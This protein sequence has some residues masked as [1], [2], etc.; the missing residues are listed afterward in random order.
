MTSN[1][2]LFNSPINQ[3]RAR[4]RIKKRLRKDLGAKVASAMALAQ[5]AVLNPELLTEEERQF[6]E[7]VMSSNKSG[8][9][10][11]A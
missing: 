3:E 4:D 11:N 10:D 6:H 5:K 8:N 2:E 9:F 7:K 1:C